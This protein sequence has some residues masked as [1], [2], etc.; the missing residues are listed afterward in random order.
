MFFWRRFQLVGG[1]ALMVALL[2]GCGSATS[3]TPTPPPTSPTLPPPPATTTISGTVTATN[4]GQPLAGLSVITST[5]TRT[6]DAAGAFSF[7]FAGAGTDSIFLVTI[8]GPSV[9]SRTTYFRLNT[10]SGIAL[11]VFSLDQGFDL[12]YF[13]QLARGVL[14]GSSL[15]PIRRWTRNPSIYIRTIAD[16]GR[17]IDPQ[18][19][20]IVESTIR[21]TI[22]DW[23]GGQLSVASVERGTDT[24]ES[25]GGWLTVK[26]A[27]GSSEECGQATVGVEGGT[28][29]IEPGTPGCRCAGLAIDPAV[30]RH[31][32]GHAMGMFHTDRTEDVMYPRR[33][34][35]CSMTLSTREKEYAAYIYSRSVG[36]TDPDNDPATTVFSVPAS[37]GDAL[38]AYRR[39]R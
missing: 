32:F 37:L 5:A 17:A 14:D 21:D 11:S 27:S 23:T 15:R 39:R 7:T 6:T 2:T 19:L 9:V 22:G 38:T 31:E 16:N 28:V 13:R 26:W 25:V 10:H 36:N 20:D 34:G 29:Q 18:A 35:S 3:P 30:V 8:N 24:R 33:S 1:F 12:T 4:G